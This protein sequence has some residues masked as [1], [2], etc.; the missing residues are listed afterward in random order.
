MKNS[1]LIALVAGAVVVAGAAVAAIRFFASSPSVDAAVELVPEDAWL[2]TN[3]FVEPSDDQKRALDE[4]LSHFPELESTEDALNE[5]GDLLDDLLD[6]AGL[7]F[8]RDIEPWLGE[9]IAFFFAGEQGPEPDGAL[10]LATTDAD[11]TRDAVRTAVMQADTVGGPQSASYEGTDYEIVEQESGPAVALGSVDD[12]FVV[13]TEQ[14][15]KDVVDV[16]GG[17]ASLGGSAPYDD[18][19]EPLADDPII[20]T[21]FDTAAFFDALRASGDLGPDDEAALEA[22]DSIPGFS[23]AGPAALAVSARGDGVL[24]E[25][26]ST[27]PEGELG[28]LAAAYGGSDLLE[29]M[30][31]DAWLTFAAAD[32]GTSI[33]A[34]FDAFAN[35]PGFSRDA[36][37]RG[38]REET[39]LS[40][41]DILSWMGDA[42]IFVQGTN[43]QEM[44]GG[45][46]IETSD[47][48]ATRKVMNRLRELLTQA[49]TPT[50]DVER[51]G[52]T[53]FSVSQGFPAPVYALLAD[54]LIITY[55]DKATNDA[56]APDEAMGDDP[57]FRRAQEALGDGMRPALFVD[58]D[59]VLTLVDFAMGFGGMQTDPTYQQ[60]VKPWLEP[61]SYLVAGARTDGD[62]IVQAFFVGVDE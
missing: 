53:G 52:F 12:F 62:R 26:T 22:F 55:G 60:E 18:T 36:I 39:G 48:E 34:F 19:L 43:F 45:V 7:E 8:E 59:G 20:S 40:L 3:L 49:G 41:D 37:E 38:L 9:Q 58:M 21:Y 30:P 1:V 42:A 6:E 4:L 15:F 44:G 46:T 24:M 54:R 29:Q 13:G 47:P 16:A 5:L 14:G 32:V 51:D 33:G 35:L 10:L 57:T 27:V 2:Y 23:D 31:A 50:N 25:S 56:I 28:E 11:A 17:G 61:L